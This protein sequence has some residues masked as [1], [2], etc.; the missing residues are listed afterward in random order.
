MAKIISAGRGDTDRATTAGREGSAAMTEE[1]NHFGFDPADGPPRLSQVEILN[2]V[3]RTITST[4]DIDELLKNT[5]ETIRELL[6][7]DLVAVGLVEGDT[8]FAVL[9]AVSTLGPASLPLGHS[10]AFGEGVTGTVVQT[11]RSLL[12][13]DCREFPNYVEAAAG[14]RCEICCPLAV[15]GKV[16]GYLDAE[17]AEPYAF[18]SQDLLIIE[19][20]AEHISQAVENARNLRQVNELR[21]DLSSMVVHDL[22]SPLMVVVWTL[23]QLE[24]RLRGTADEPLTLEPAAVTSMGRAITRATAACDEMLIRI[25]GLVELQRIETGALELKLAPCPVLD[26]G[27][28]VVER[29]S[30]IARA[31]E[32]HLQLD[33]EGEG[34]AATVDQDLIAR[35]LENLIAN[36]LRFTPKGGGV[37]LRMEIAGHGAAKVILTIPGEALL[38]SVRDTGPGIPIE[39]RDRVFDKF[40]TV[41]G[42]TDGRKVRTGLGL[43]FCQQAVTAHQG[44]IWVAETDGPGCTICALLPIDGPVAAGG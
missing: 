18:D 29:M 11:G 44:A 34:I 12:V 39:E 22:R 9:K 25:D 19:T 16:I 7:Y 10:Q 43:A 2:R 30:V 1:G 4:V 6:G 40:A 15:R 3:T 14:L 35:V 31:K 13:P 5:V 24:E 37:T 36:A 41:E 23:S 17:A 33:Q 8:Q 28:S 26:L 38:I 20:I 32:I 42:A 21:E 27:R